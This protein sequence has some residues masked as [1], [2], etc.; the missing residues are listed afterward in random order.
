MQKSIIFNSR[1]IICQLQ[2]ESQKH[3]DRHESKLLLSEYENWSQTWHVCAQKTFLLQAM[4][5]SSTANKQNHR[6]WQ[7]TNKRCNR[8][9][10]REFFIHFDLEI[11]REFQFFGD[12]YK[13]ISSSGLILILHSGY[14]FS[15][16]YMARMVIVELTS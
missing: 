12:S 2:T 9:E 16:I 13:E 14:T 4:N 3:W 8:Y 7:L 11:L 5:L 6:Y 10:T 1:C 15:D